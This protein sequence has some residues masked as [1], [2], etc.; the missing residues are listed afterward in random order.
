MDGR[1]EGGRGEA[2]R[3][4]LRGIGP[5]IYHTLIYR[6][7]LETDFSPYPFSVPIKAA[8]Q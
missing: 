8:I 5:L 7:V 3:A 2:R 4:L 6:F 1:G